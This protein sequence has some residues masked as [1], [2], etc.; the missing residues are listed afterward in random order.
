MSD[1]NDGFVKVVRAECVSGEVWRLWVLAGTEIRQSSPERYKTLLSVQ[2][3]DFA[4]T[5]E[6]WYLR[7]DDETRRLAETYGASPWGSSRYDGDP[8]TPDWEK[9]AALEFYWRIRGW[10]PA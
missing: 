2:L 4:R 8:N 7:V 6:V 10:P 3:N 5:G 1:Y 9:K